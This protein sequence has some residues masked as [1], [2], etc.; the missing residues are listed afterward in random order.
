MPIRRL[1]SLTLLLLALGSP[2]AQA[3][4]FTGD[5]KAGMDRS[6]PPAADA[7]SAWIALMD[8]R[9]FEAAWEGTAQLFRKEQDRNTWIATQ[10]RYREAVSPVSRRQVISSR[11]TRTLLPFSTIDAVTFQLAIRFVSETLGIETIVLVKESDGAWRVASYLTNPGPVT[12]TPAPL[13]Y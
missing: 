8:Q 4:I 1:A 7:M 10:Y 12:T 3:Q 6:V 13:G 11:Y 2:T 5:D 9:T